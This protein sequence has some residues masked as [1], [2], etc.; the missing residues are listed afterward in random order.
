MVDV[1][2]AARRVVSESANQAIPSATRSN[3]KPYRPGGIGACTGASDAHAPTGLHHRQRRPQPIPDD[4]VPAVVEPVEPRA[5]PARHAAVPTFSSVTR[6]VDDVPA[7]ASPSSHSPQRTA[8]GPFVM[9]GGPRAVDPLLVRAA[10]REPTER[11]P[12]WFMRQAGRSLPEYRAIRERHAFFE[13]NQSA[14]LTAEVTLQP[15][16]RTGSTRR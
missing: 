16:R 13:I 8:S 10:R 5:N 12:V 4:R 6:A 9:G 11:T 14:E 3:A 15:V 1:D 7:S 2:L